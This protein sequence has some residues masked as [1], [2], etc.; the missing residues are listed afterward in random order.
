MSISIILEYDVNDT[1]IFRFFK[2]NFKDNHFDSDLVWYVNMNI[3]WFY[4]I[5]NYKKNHGFS[6]SSDE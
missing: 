4:K 2:C 1:N 3:F 6:A 5:M